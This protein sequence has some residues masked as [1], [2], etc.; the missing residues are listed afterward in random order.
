[1]RRSGGKSG[2]SI[3]INCSF[4]LDN[5]GPRGFVKHG[6][7][8]NVHTKRPVKLGF[9]WRS[10]EPA[11]STKSSLDCFVGWKMPLTAC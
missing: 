10:F 5:H 3:S 7:I 1:M 9:C 4:D 2:S 6:L 8:S 11:Q